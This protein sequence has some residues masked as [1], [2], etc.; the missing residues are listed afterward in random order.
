MSPRNGNANSQGKDEEIGNALL[1]MLRSLPSWPSL[2][3]S[4]ALPSICRN[5][6]AEKMAAGMAGIKR[7]T[8]PRTRRQSEL[9][10]MT[11]DDRSHFDIKEDDTLMT[12]AGTCHGRR[13]MPS[14]PSSAAVSVFRRAIMPI[15]AYHRW[16]S[17]LYLRR[18]F[19]TLLRV[20]TR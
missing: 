15:F 4:V 1:G 10:M 17:W 20:L 14:C 19:K 16:P 5:A 7:P 8:R 9:T 11:Q 12:K 6:E 18:S 3:L 2:T 13:M